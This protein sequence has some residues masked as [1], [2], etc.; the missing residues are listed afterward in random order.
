MYVTYSV[1]SNIDLIV[2]GLD[3]LEALKVV[4]SNPSDHA[5]LNTLD[6][7]EQLMSYSMMHCAGLERVFRDKQ[8]FLTIVE[9]AININHSV[10]YYFI[11]ILSSCPAHFSTALVVMLL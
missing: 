10:S 9:T 4:P 3:L 7:L 5:A 8:L 6:D 2:S 11:I 1:N